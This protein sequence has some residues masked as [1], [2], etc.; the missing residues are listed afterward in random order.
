M[1]ALYERYYDA[2]SPGTFFED[3]AAKDHVILLCAAG[4]LAGFSASAR[5]ASST[6]GSRAARSR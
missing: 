1:F 2:T 4:R 6:R 5:S 3:L